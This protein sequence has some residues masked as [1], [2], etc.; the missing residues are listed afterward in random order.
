[1]RCESCG[2]GEITQVGFGAADGATYRYCR[3]CEHGWW[4]SRGQHLRIGDILAAAA[5]IEPDRR[6]APRRNA[7]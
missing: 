6:N 7:A 3:V 1:M 4:E 5:G 2:A